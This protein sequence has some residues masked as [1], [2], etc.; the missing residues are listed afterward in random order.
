MKQ[1]KW[2]PTP[3][4]QKFKIG[5]R[6]KIAKDLGRTM[7]PHFKSG[8][9]ATVAH[10]YKQMFGGDNVTSYCLNVEGKGLVSW[11]YEHQLTEVKE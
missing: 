11:Y 1:D 10:S 7:T 5:T 3:K 2:N 6:V 4:G 9:E 8:C